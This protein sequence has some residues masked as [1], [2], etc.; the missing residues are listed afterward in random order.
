[1]LR[2]SRSCRGDAEKHQDRKHH[3]LEA[4]GNHLVNGNLHE[5][6]ICSIIRH[7]LKNTGLALE[8][9]IVT[10]HVVQF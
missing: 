8:P 3:R 4:G 7:Y 9:W 10:W 5:H 2:E 6:T 1:L